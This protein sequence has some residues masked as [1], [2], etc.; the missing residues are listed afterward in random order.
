M[1]SLK[2]I[3]EFVKDDYLLDDEVEEK[4]RAKIPMILAHTT[5]EAFIKDFRQVYTFRFE[6]NI[7]VIYESL[8]LNEEDDSIVWDAFFA[9]E[10]ERGFKLAEKY[11]FASNLYDLSVIWMYKD[12]HKE[13][14]EKVVKTC[15]KY[16]RSKHLK[17]RLIALEHLGDWLSSIEK[18]TAFYP[19]MRDLQTMLKDKKRKIRLRVYRTLKELNFVPQNYKMG[20]IDRIFYRKI[21][22]ENA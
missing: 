8:I 20:W 19:I 12:S 1:N 17:I 16:I 5:K 15:S 14:S 7:E 21:E 3:N 4:I 6:H 11:G 18:R 2:E 10:Y 13:L 9:E 22:K